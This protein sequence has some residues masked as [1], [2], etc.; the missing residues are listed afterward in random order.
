MTTTNRPPRQRRPTGNGAERKTLMKAWQFVEQGEPLTLNDVQ[1]PT[2]G[3][4]DVIIDVKAAGI[5]HSDV[6]YLNGTLTPVLAF[7]PIT[8][9]HEI[10]G[11]VSAIGENVDTF[12]VG[13][14]VVVPAKVEGAGTSLNGGFAPKVSSPAAYVIPLPDGVDWDQ[15]AAATDAGMTSYHAAITR[16]G[17]TAGTKVGIIGFGGLGS[18]GAQAALAVGAEVYVAETNET[19]HD[20]AR[21]L[22]VAAVSTDIADFSDKGL[23]VIIDYAGF[24]TTT[25]AAILA[26]KPG[27][28]VVQ[29]GL[30]VAEAT[31]PL[32]Q[33]VLKSV[34]LVGSVAGSNEDCAA[35][36]DLIAAGK[37]SSRVTHVAFDEIKDG[38]DRLDRGEVV[39][40]L[41]AML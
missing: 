6:G 38:V 12:A 33:L 7:H 14:R 22:G 35:V 17:V 27:G 21:Q 3:P 16:G 37:L 19:V 25:A 4:D 40:R 11:V 36:L 29:V 28:R 39:G 23:D 9:G 34:D 2:A 24:G 8:L 13:D 1:E 15:A 26:V 31:I 41:V 10:A 30:G 18:L 32:L 5:C 20:F